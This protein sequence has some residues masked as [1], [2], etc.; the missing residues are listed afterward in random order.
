MLLWTSWDSDCWLLSLPRVVFQR[1]WVVQDQQL[2]ACYACSSSGTRPR[3][4][5]QL[6]GQEKGLVRGQIGSRI[7]S[8]QAGSEEADRCRH[9][10]LDPEIKQRISAFK[11]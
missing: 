4:Q 7:K 5:W 3:V 6:P 8:G 1:A 10:Q 2:G 9:R 11:S